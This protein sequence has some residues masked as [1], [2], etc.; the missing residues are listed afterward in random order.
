M[1]YYYILVKKFEIGHPNIISIDSD[2]M[3]IKIQQYCYLLS[4]HLSNKI[5]SIL[6]HICMYIYMLQYS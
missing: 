6:I 2:N 5:C 1:K 4:F 3:V